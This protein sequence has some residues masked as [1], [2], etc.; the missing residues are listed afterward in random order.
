VAEAASSGPAGQIFFNQA[1]VDAVQVQPWWLS[2][3]DECP[4]PTSD[5]LGL[6][7][8]CGHHQANGSQSCKGVTH[9]KKVPWMQLLV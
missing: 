5:V 1:A 8:V 3:S 9:G 7:F 2:F 6:Q 4:R